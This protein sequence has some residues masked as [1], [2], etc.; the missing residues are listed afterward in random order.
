MYLGVC[1]ELYKPL[2]IFLFILDWLFVQERN[3]VKK[4]TRSLAGFL[5]NMVEIGLFFTIVDILCNSTNSYVSVWFTVKD[6]IYSVFMLKQ[7]SGLKNVNLIFSLADIQI[8]ISWFLYV[9]IIGNVVGSIRRGE[10]AD[11]KRGKG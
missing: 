7:I 10:K 11:Y 8:I 9:V 5:L 2:E 1:V 4:Y 3:P 6:N